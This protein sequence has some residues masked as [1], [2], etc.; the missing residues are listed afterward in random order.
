IEELGREPHFRALWL[1]CLTEPDVAELVRGQAR[2][3]TDAATLARRG[4]RAWEA[5]EGNPFAALETAHALRDGRLAVADDA[6]AVPAR[7]REVIARRLDAPSDRARRLAGAA[8]VIGR[9]CD[10]LLLRGV[11]GLGERETAEALDE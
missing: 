1:P 8:A 7:V 3:G 4:R 11:A 6:I 5:S 10:V 2:A 9:E